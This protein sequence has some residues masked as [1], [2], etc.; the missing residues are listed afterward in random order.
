MYNEITRDTE[1]FI[2]WNEHDDNND[3]C[4][5]KPTELPCLYQLEVTQNELFLENLINF[6][7]ILLGFIGTWIIFYTI[8]HSICLSLLWALLIFF[9]TK[10][11]IDIIK[12]NL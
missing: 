6:I 10:I 2:D 7:I 1:E 5:C 11:T 12:W 3:F 4:N 9:T 8:N